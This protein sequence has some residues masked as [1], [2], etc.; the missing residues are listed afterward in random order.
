MRTIAVADWPGTKQELTARIAAF[1]AAKEAHKKTEDV[2]APFEIQL[3]EELAA[4]GEAFEIYKEPPPVVLPPP[5]PERLAQIARLAA[6]ESV[7]QSDPQ[8]VLL[9]DMDKDQFDAWWAANV[10]N[11]AQA[12]AVLKRLTRVMLVRLL[13]NP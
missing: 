3:V 9:R 10:T 12:I 5:T 2:P 7:V 11:A 13:Q 6:L 8:I 4:S 1:L